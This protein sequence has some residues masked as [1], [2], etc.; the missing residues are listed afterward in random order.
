MKATQFADTYGVSYNAVY[1]HKNSKNPYV[2]SEGKVCM[3]NVDALT[4]R[5]DFFDRVYMESQNFYFDFTDKMT[6]TALSK[7]LSNEF[8]G[9]YNT[10]I[11][12][13]RKTLFSSAYQDK[14]LL[15]YKVTGKL[16]KFWRFSKTYMR[17]NR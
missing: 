5:R 11:M 1:V 4:R 13:L 9:T 12:F 8:G 2:Y 14:S 16:W 6:E 17:K 7:M 3:V 10:W 15:A